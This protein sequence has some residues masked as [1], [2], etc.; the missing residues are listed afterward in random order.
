M[1]HSAQDGGLSICQGGVAA[2]I[3]MALIGLEVVCKSVAQVL[4]P[5]FKQK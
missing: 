5:T 3:Q 4:C 1:G 2:R